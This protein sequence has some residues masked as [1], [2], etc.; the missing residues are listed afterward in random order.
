LTRLLKRAEDLPDKQAILKKER[1]LLVLQNQLNSSRAIGFEI[2]KQTVQGELLE[3]RARLQLATKQLYVASENVNLT[4]LDI[5]E[6]LKNIDIESQHIIVELNKGASVF[7]VLKKGRPVPGI[8]GIAAQTQLAGPAESEQLRQAQLN[9]AGIEQLLLGKILV[10]LE[11]K[12][13]IWNL[14][15]V[16]AKVTDHEKAREAYDQIAKNQAYLKAVHDYV[17]QLRQQ[18]LTWVT[19]QAVKELDAGA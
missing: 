1:D 16:Y 17:N 3:N 2:E 9:N 4:Q 12:R 18:V 10:Y 14:R 6:V 19:D 15:W 11:L 13:D 7:E 5:A 8:T